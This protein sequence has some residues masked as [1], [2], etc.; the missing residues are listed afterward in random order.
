MSRFSY[1]PQTLTKSRCRHTNTHSENTLYC[2]CASS[3]LTEH[4]TSNLPEPPCQP[5]S[6][7][8][9][10]AL[11]RA[12]FFLLHVATHPGASPTSRSGALPTELSS[13]T[14]CLLGQ[15]ANVH[16][17]NDMA[18][19]SQD[20]FPTAERVSITSSVVWLRIS[21]TLPTVCV[22]V[23]MIHDFLTLYQHNWGSCQVGPWIT[24]QWCAWPDW[25][26]A[27]RAYWPKYASYSGETL[28]HSGCHV[29]SGIGRAEKKGRASQVHHVLY[30]Q[31][32]LTLARPS[33]RWQ[34]LFVFTP[35]NV[36]KLNSS[37]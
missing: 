13:R 21:F 28:G 26:T 36:T 6:L 1:F 19:C 35:V 5:V 24:F 7:S 11:V 18:I 27:L 10:A 15:W 30:T 32:V 16:H 12:P 31:P 22:S 29:T 2:S 14:S 17:Q 20:S 3:P 8:R 33:H 23:S 37:N 4:H 34:Y 9:E 25:S